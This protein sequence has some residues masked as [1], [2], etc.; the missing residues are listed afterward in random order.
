MPFSKCSTQLSPSGRHLLGRDPVRVLRR[1]LPSPRIGRVPGW[2]P[3]KT[4]NRG[5]VHLL[6]AGDCRQRGRER[7]DG[8]TC[9]CRGVPRVCER[10]YRPAFALLPAW[11]SGRQLPCRAVS[12]EKA[13]SGFL[14][15]P[16][17]PASG[18]HW[19]ES[20]RACHWAHHGEKADTA[21]RRLGLHLL[22]QGSQRVGCPVVC[23]LNRGD[24]RLRKD[25]LPLKLLHRQLVP[26]L[27]QQLSHT[28]E[29]LLGIWVQLL[30]LISFPPCPKIVWL[31]PTD[32]HRPS[33]RRW[34]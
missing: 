11:G 14:V 30:E 22:A 34:E 19:A 5:D 8:Q 23:W 12:P 13:R 1:N 6:L 15:H 16:W 17:A 26:V 18:G 2:A 10:A 27:G 33:G 21:H 7:V 3:G 24:A 31:H 29:L 32:T 4:A 25:C 28:L 9:T 20:Q